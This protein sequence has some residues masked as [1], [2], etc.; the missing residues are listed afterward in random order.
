MR[1]DEETS[2]LVRTA[3]K[4]DGTTFGTNAQVAFMGEEKKNKEFLDKT[5]INT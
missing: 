5:K 4:V 2:L 1:R 3:P